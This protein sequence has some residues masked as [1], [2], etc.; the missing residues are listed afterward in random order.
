MRAKRAMAPGPTSAGPL[1]D[2][3]HKVEGKC[4]AATAPPRATLQPS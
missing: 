4:R 3:A 2:Q 1:W